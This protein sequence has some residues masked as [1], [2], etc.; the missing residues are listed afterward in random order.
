MKAS[1]RQDIFT[2]APG[3]SH[4]VLL[5][6]MP[7]DSEAFP[8]EMLCL[9]TGPKGC[10]RRRRRNCLPRP[11]QATRRQVSSRA[12]SVKCKAH[13]PTGRTFVFHGEFRLGS[14]LAI[15]PRTFR[16]S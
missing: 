11:D 1:F 6:F 7:L 3:P 9:V 4:L 10:Y 14:V 5:C 12:I 16:M 8:F 2:M 15:L 13:H